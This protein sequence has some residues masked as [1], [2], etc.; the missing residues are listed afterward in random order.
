MLH[1]CKWHRGATPLCRFLMHSRWDFSQLYKYDYIDVT[2]K[3]YASTMAYTYLHKMVKL[4]MG[5]VDN[6]I[7]T[8]L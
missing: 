6:P 3:T 1:V 8:L 5:L 7:H 2:V 4:P